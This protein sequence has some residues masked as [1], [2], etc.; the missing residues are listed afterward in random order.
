MKHLQYFMITA[1]HQ[2]HKAIQ[3]RWLSSDKAAEKS[4]GGKETLEDN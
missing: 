2:Q 4:G 1:L 3:L